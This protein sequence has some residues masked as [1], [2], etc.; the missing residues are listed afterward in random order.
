MQPPYQ[1]GGYP[2][3]GY[4][5]QQQPQQGYP[6]QQ[7]QQQQPQQGYP[8]QQQQQ[9]Q[10]PQQGYPQQQQQYPQQGY[11][12]QPQQQYG[13]Q[14][15][16]Q[17]TPVPTEIDFLAR[18]DSDGVRFSWNIWPSSRLEATRA[19]KISTTF[20]E[21]KKKIKIIFKIILFFNNAQSIS[22]QR[23]LTSILIAHSDSL[24]RHLQVFF[25][26]IF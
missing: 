16:Q 17:Y 21:K 25:L 15:Q 1:Q 24:W 10:Q 20:F 6:Q 22:L 12:Q 3:Q 23:T 14:Q 7:Q 26:S 2:Q 4:P 19:G 18:E 13:Y 11:P 8:Q 5:Q 9:Q